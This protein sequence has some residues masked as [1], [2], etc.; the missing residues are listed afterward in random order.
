MY[1]YIY[2]YLYGYMVGGQTQDETN[3]RHETKTDRRK[4]YVG[5]A[6]LLFLDFEAG[7]R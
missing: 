1:V 4:S 2:I 7:Q 5:M 3:I 6:V